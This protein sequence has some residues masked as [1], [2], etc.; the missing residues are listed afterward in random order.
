MSVPVDNTISIEEHNRI[1]LDKDL[2]TEIE[3]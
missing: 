3:K 2:K 1:S